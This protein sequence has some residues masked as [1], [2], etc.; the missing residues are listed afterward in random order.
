VHEEEL[1]VL[2]VVDEESLVAGG[3]HV[4]GLLVGSVTDGGHSHLALETTTNAVINSL[5][6]APR[7]ADAHE[8]ITLVTVEAVSAYCVQC[9][10]S[11][12][13]RELLV[14]SWFP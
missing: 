8:P 12:R 11:G 13:K 10:S 7:G 14:P 5:G 1:D 4:A 3:H 9:Q 6:L 2:G